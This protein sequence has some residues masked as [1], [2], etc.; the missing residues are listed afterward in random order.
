MMASHMAAP[1]TGHLRTV[2]HI[3]AYLNGHDR[4]QL[5]FDGKEFKHKL[6]QVV[7]WTGYYPGV[8]EAIPPNTP[9]PLGKPVQM[10][11]YV[12][13]DHTGDLVTRRSRSGVLLFLNRAPI[14]WQSKKQSSI[15]TSMFGSEF[16]ALNAAVEMIK[17]LHYKVQMMG[18]PLDEATHVLVDNM[19]VMYNTTQPEST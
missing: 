2:L 4:S 3:F 1:R 14:M 8:K 19:S 12:D 9:K 13:S 16:M 5:V 10:T 18:I 11:C 15:E 17:G 6:A 7:D